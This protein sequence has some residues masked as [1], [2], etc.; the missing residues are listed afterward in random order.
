M[1]QESQLRAGLELWRRHPEIG[2]FDAVLAA[3]ARD[4]GASMIVSADRACA[5]VAGVEHTIP[6]EAGV[7]A[8]LGG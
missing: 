3:A 6:D 2:C 7:A 1:T 8:L 5:T 4:I